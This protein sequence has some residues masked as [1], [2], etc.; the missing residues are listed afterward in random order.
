VIL[1]S[2]DSAYLKSAIEELENQSNI[3]NIAIRGSQDAQFSVDRIGSIKL[4]SSVTWATQLPIGG[5]QMNGL[6]KKIRQQISM[7]VWHI[8]TQACVLRQ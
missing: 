4:W 7:L 1:N 3:E 5:K 2:N 8:G 6:F